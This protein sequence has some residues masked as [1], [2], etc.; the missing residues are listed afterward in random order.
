MSRQCGRARISSR[1][2]VCSLALL[3]VAL[4]GTLPVYS[5]PRV[6][7]HAMGSLAGLLGQATPSP[8]CFEVTLVPR[9]AG[10]LRS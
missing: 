1:H 3:E 8:A 6:L 2:S 5:S 4:R 7:G 9:G 10:Y